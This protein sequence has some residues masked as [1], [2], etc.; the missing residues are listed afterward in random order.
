MVQHNWQN[1]LGK[2]KW[3]FDKSQNKDIPYDIALELLPVSVSQ[4][5]NLDNI[6]RIDTEYDVL[7]VLT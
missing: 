2:S 4:L 3:L 5:D 7:W 1:I 6:A